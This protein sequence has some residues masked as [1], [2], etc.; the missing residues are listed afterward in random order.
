VKS[1]PCC[2]KLTI[3]SFNV[4]WTGVCFLLLFSAFQPI[5]SL[6]SGT[7]RKGYGFI[8]I[9]VLY[10]SFSVASLFASQFVRVMG[11]KLGL[12]I[13]AFCYLLY[14]ATLLVLALVP[15]LSNDAYKALYFIASSVIGIGA[16][17]LWTSQGSLLTVMADKSN[18]GALNG[19]FWSLFMF[20]YVFG[21]LITEFLLSRFGFSKKQTERKISDRFFFFVVALLLLFCILCFRQ[22]LV[23]VWL[24]C[25]SFAPLRLFLLLAVATPSNLSIFSKLFA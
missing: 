13:G 1:R 22:L 20:S 11:Q 9:A 24:V 18:L 15:D 23:W 10:G 7:A 16:S 5:Q 3:G 4:I 17:V 14:I 2:G 8:G 6:Q 19:V 25:C 12:F 21:G